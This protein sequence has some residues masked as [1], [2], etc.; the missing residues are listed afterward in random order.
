MPTDWAG[1]ILASLFFHRESALCVALRST[2]DIIFKALSLNCQSILPNH[3]PLPLECASVVPSFLA[4]ALSVSLLPHSYYPHFRQC[5]FQLNPRGSLLLPSISSFP[6]RNRHHTSNSTCLSP[7]F[8]Q[9]IIR[10]PH[11]LENRR[12]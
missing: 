11:W 3:Y 2:F 6:I 5:E 1:V 4:C 10:I 7:T 8:S 9:H 12:F